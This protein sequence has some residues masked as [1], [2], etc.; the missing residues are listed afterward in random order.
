MCFRE[1]FLANY[2][3]TIRSY[4]EEIETFDIDRKYK[5]YLYYRRVFQ[6]I[7]RTL[8]CYYAV[9]GRTAGLDEIM[10]L[11]GYFIYRWTGAFPSAYL[12]KHIEYI[13][14]KVSHSELPKSEVIDFPALFGMENP[15]DDDFLEEIK[16]CSDDPYLRACR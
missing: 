15:V 14:N 12:V 11:V 4:L 9:H 3:E 16:N 10:K 13:A 2:R 8:K 7:N 1:E 5:L 6:R